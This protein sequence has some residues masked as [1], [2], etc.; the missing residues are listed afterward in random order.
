MKRLSSVLIFLTA[1]TTSLS[2]LSQQVAGRIISSVGDVTILRDGQK[3]AGYIGTQLL[4]GDTVRL[5]AESN[6]QIYFTDSSIVALRPDTEFKISEYRFQADK[7]EE[8]RAF[9]NLVK[10]GMRTITGL[11]GKLDNRNYSVNTPVMIIG[12]R[13]T[14]YGIV[15]SDVPFK[16]AN[17]TT[18]PPGSYGAVTNGQIVVTNGTGTHDFGADQ[19]F[20]VASKDTA[21]QQLIA[22][23]SFLSDKLEGRSRTRAAA[24]VAPTNQ[25]Q[26]QSQQQQ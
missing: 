24:A 16:N 9:L 5:G 4:S 11:I 3:V 12:L 2:C 18:A 13:G 8:G 20:H 19:Y 1:L 25:P 26:Q 15:H 23:P 7:P 17:G 14:H 6:A 10:G 22:P 21:P